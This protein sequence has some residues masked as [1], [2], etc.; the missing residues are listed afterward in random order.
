MAGLSEAAL[1]DRD[2]DVGGHGLSRYAVESWVEP[3]E[4]ATYRA[5]AGF[6]VASQRPTVARRH[7]TPFRS[8]AEV[9]EE[10]GRLRQIWTEETAFT[11]T[12]SQRVMHSAYQR[13]IGLGPQVIPLILQEFTSGRVEHWFWAL[14][15]VSGEDAA[16]GQQSLSDAAECWVSWGRERGY[17]EGA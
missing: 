13:I 6:K 10:F 15:A 14:I 8:D 1:R 4:R 3:E 16:V 11:S 9:A 5:S 7:I 2:F 17:V 12:L